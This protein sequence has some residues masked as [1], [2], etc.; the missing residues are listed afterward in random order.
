VWKA[1]ETCGINPF[2]PTAFSFQFYGAS[3]GEGMG[4]VSCLFGRQRCFG[5][6][7][8]IVIC[9]MVDRQKQRCSFPLPRC[10]WSWCSSQDIFVGVVVLSRE[11]FLDGWLLRKLSCVNGRT[12]LIPV[13]HGIGDCGEW[14]F[15]LVTLDN[16]QGK[17]RSCEWK[18]IAAGPCEIE[19][20]HRNKE[21][22]SY[23]HVEDSC[24]DVIHNGNYSICCETVNKLF[25]PTV[26]RCGGCE[27]KLTGKVTLELKFKG[28]HRSWSTSAVARWSYIIS[29]VGGALGCGLTI[30]V[31]KTSEFSEDSGF[32]GDYDIVHSRIKDASTLLREK[33]TDI[34]IVEET[35]IEE[36]VQSFCGVW[37]LFYSGS[38]G[39]TL[40][41]PTFNLRGDF[42]LE[43]ESPLDCNGRLTVPDR[44]DVCLPVKDCA[45][46]DCAVKDCGGLFGCP[47]H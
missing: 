28:E 39:Y 27:I 20:E 31:K 10:P 35:T 23:E 47:F 21:L 1:G 38:Y 2:A 19:F 14:R 8:M 4:A 11:I 32:M 24:N 34:L 9:G 6:R 45:V 15:E 42:I 29:F 40:C 22:W 41:N 3:S 46:K 17:R 44:C 37:P 5:N 43:L 13:F 7:N 30:S 16:C 26:S 25:I 12:T 33:L 18:E 36:L